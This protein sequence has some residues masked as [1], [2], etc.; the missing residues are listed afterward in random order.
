METRSIIR[1]EEPPPSHMRGP[2]RGAASKW[3]SL[4]AQ[5]REHPGR[6]A[7]VDEGNNASLID[8]IKFGRAVCFRPAGDFEATTRKIPG[9]NTTRVYARFLGDGHV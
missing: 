2:G 3:D 9:T 5:L 1:W 8:T 7:L 4:A 6:W